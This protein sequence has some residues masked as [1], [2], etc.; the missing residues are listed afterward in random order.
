MIG[1][2]DGIEV[3]DVG[4]ASPLPGASREGGSA[5]Q[6]VLSHAVAIADQCAL[7]L[8][9]ILEGRKICKVWPG[10][11]MLKCAWPTCGC[12]SD[13]Q[14]MQQIA[15]VEPTASVEATISGEART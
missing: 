6:S 9:R 13:V 4:L 1:L 5:R 11:G 15:H 10:E 3:D 14:E 2:T 8:E 12:L 7:R